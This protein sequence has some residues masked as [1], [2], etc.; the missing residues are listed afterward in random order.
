MDFDG[1]LDDVGDDLPG[2]M[3]MACHPVLSPEARVA[4]TLRLLAGLTTA[5]IARPSWCPRRRSPSGSPGPSARS[6]P[7]AWFELPSPAERA[8]RLASVLEV[9]YLVFN[10]GYAATA[11]DAL[12]RGE[13]AGEAMRLGRVLTTLGLG[14]RPVRSASVRRRPRC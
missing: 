3:F 4:L 1:G 7:P 12:V 6:P 13:L 5:E 2:L 11:G 10:E 14:E 8:D 9:V